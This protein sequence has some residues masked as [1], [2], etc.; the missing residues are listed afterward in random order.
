MQSFMIVYFK[1]T[2]LFHISISLDDYIVL[3]LNL[4]NS[5]KLSNLANSSYIEQ[6]NHSLKKAVLTGK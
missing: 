4:E 6:I 5:T 2:Y 1:S 3:P